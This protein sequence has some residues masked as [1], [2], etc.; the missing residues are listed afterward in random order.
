M[1]VLKGK[2]PSES[3]VS[4]HVYKLFPNDMNSNGTAFGGM[5]MSVLDRVALVVA[6]RHSQRICVTVSVDS[7]SFL[8]PAERGDILIFKA[9][10]NNAWKT[11]MEVGIRVVAQDYHTSTTRHVLSAYFT[12]VGL[13]ENKKPVQIP[14]VLPETLIERRRFEEANIRRSQRIAKAEERKKMRASFS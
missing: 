1:S 2:S 4:D 13:D 8:A 11:S 10:M 14:P 12:F 7:I 3:A 5:I 6:E 9:S